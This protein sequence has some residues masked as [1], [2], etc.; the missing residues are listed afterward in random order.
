MLIELFWILLGI[1]FIGKELLKEKSEKVA[2]QEYK[3]K[4]KIDIQK[5][6]TLRGLAFDNPKEFSQR[7]GRPFVYT[8]S[9]ALDEAMKEIARKEGWGYFDRNELDK[10][11][12]Y[13]RIMGLKEK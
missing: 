5:Q 8:S 10:D 2:W 1:C 3:R 4:H 6:L 13:R 7:L 12:E 11:P 9:A